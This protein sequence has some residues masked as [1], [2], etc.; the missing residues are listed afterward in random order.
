MFSLSLLL[1]RLVVVGWLLLLLLLLRLVAVVVDTIVVASDAV[2]P[3]NALLLLSLLPLPLLQSAHVSW[4]PGVAQSARDPA[5]SSSAACRRIFVCLQTQE[6]Q[7]LL[8]AAL[9]RR[10]CPM[11]PKQFDVLVRIDADFLH[12]VLK[13]YHSCLHH[14]TCLAVCAVLALWAASVQF[15]LMLPCSLL[16]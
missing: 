12:N 4:H 16:H 5:R 14:W 9:W 6:G 10:P 8:Q 1:L 7:R 13:P 15:V 3:V 11:H 2:P